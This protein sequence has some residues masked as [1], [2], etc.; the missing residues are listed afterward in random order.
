MKAL[1]Y[2]LAKKNPKIPSV[3]QTDLPM[4]KVEKAE[5]LVRVHFAGLNNFDLETSKGKRN[6]AVARSARKKTIIS[7]VEMAGV[8]ESD[9]ERIKKGDRVMGYTNIFTGPFFHAEYIAV[10]EGNLAVIPKD[11]S[12]EG[13]TSL[14][15]GALTSINALERIAHLKPQDRVLIT[16]ATGSVGIASVQLAKHMGATVSALCHSTQR[17]FAL[18]QGASYVYAYDKAELP[19]DSGQFDLVF[20]AAASMS[21]A[22]ANCFLKAT[23]IYITTM[24]QLDITGFIRSLFSKKKWGY[25]ME[26][27]T[28][29]TRMERLRSLIAQQAFSPVIDSIY[30]LS[31]AEDAFERQ[32]KPGKKGKIL[33]D[34]RNVGSAEKLRNENT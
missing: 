7:G 27:N 25:L 2:V 21:F 23:G 8:S 29:A 22:S 15:G 28:D 1:S 20:D 4:P 24:P 17:D 16:G 33:L 5:V 13:A 18:S 9:G 3:Q 26:Y 11:V 14:V 34:F 12:L 10:P 30:E 6:R 31:V 32:L 19:E